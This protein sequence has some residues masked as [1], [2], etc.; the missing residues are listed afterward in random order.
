MNGFLE[1]IREQTAIVTLGGKAVTVTRARLGLHLELN[2]AADEFDNAPGS[3]EMAAAIR[4][5][6]G[7]LGIETEGV[8]PVE[9]LSAYLTLRELNAWKW[10]LAFMKDTGREPG[11]PETYDYP[12]RNWT[13]VVHKIASRYGWTRDYIF[14]LYPEEA[15]AYLQE[16]LISEHFEAEERYRLSELAYRFD[17]VTRT[18]Q[19]V[20]FAKP[21]WMVNNEL[22]K[23]VR[24]LRAML[25]FG[26]KSLSGE[27]IIYH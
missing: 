7:L 5:Y 8:R 13:W 17:K 24:M 9:V 12:D 19:Y 15:A 4:R 10:V 18:S 25:P 16:I 6:F 26:V 27:E 2:R 21:G 1:A 11:Q 22:P 20:P 3:P 23:P 14:S